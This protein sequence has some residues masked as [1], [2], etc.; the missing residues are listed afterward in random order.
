MSLV[1]P[2]T[3][4]T[5]PSSNPEAGRPAHAVARA[6]GEKHRTGKRLAVSACMMAPS[7]WVR[8]GG[9]AIALPRNASVKAA[10][11]SRVSC[12]RQA[13]SNA[14][15][16]RSSSPMRPNSCDSVMLAPGISS[17]RIRAASC[18]RSAVRDVAGE[19]K[20]QAFLCTNLAAD[21]T[22]ILRWFVRRLSIEVTFAE[23]RY[24]LGVETRRQ[25]SD[26]AIARTT[27]A[28]LG[29]SA[30][31]TLRA[32]ELSAKSARSSRAA[33]WYPKPLP[34]FS[35]AIAVRREFWLRHHLQTPASTSDP[36]K[37]LRSTFNALMNVAC[38]VA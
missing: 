34:T 26:A 21:P 23:V 19:F 12:C 17:A 25:W 7:F 4:T 35:D 24:H 15:F 13:F 37:M 16:S 38:Y 14:T 30:L 11:V 8:Y 22:D 28:P 18:S 32:H 20:P 27:P 29:P 1:A 3:S 31:I 2:P 10:T 5:T 33:S 6:G 36:L 9:A